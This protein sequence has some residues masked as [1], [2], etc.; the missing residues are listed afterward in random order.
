MKWSIPINFDGDPDK[1]KTWGKFVSMTPRVR[2]TS[3]WGL[4]DFVWC[5]PKPKGEVLRTLGVEFV[6]HILIVDDEE[7][8]CWVLEQALTKEGHKVAVSAS[9]EQAFVLAKKQKP[10]AIVLDVRLP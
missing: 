10:D 6:S 2:S 5:P 9:A 3:P 4:I 8:V 7:A 1:I